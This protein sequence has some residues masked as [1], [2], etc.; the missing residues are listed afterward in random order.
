MSEREHRFGL[1]GA[2]NV[3]FFVITGVLGGV[4]LAAM[5]QQDSFDPRSRPAASAFR[6]CRAWARH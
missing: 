6:S 3:L 2:L 1:Y 4:L 5:R